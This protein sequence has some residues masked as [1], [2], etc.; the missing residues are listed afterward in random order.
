MEQTAKD[1][2]FCLVHNPDDPREQINITSGSFSLRATQ[3]KK[4]EALARKTAVAF[5]NALSIAE[6]VYNQQEISEESRVGL[7]HLKLDLM[8]GSNFAWRMV[9]NHMLIMRSSVALEN[10]PKSKTIPPI[11]SDQKV[12]LFH[13]PF[14][15]TTLF[16]GE[17]AKL[18]RVNKFIRQQ[19]LRLILLNSPW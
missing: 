15:G 7:H 17:L 2:P 8:A 3:L 6:Y 9:H 10:L 4:H 14:K 11:D 13:A 12:A 1:Q 16:G 5:S 19:P 18:H